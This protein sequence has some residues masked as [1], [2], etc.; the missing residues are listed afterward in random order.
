[1]SLIARELPDPYRFEFTTATPGVDLSS[2]FELVIP[3]TTVSELRIE[4]LG[5]TSRNDDAPSNIWPPTG[6]SSQSGG[7]NETLHASY[8]QLEMVCLCCTS[9]R[10]V[11]LSIWDFNDFVFSILSK[12]VLSRRIIDL[13]VCML[14]NGLCF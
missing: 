10:R 12:L 13:T 8:E 11:K 14:F 2:S 3:T 6:F 5:V 7:F 1:M 9:L 4:M